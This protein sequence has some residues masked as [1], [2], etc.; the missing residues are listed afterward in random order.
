MENE[1]EIEMMR[2]VIKSQT[3]CEEVI[4]VNDGIILIIYPWDGKCIPF[5]YDL[6]EIEWDNLR[7]VQNCRLDSTKNIVVGYT[8]AV[9]GSKLGLKK[10]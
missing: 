1:D 6:S 10:E 7:I 9:S 4:V 8:F 3:G 2:S 5:T